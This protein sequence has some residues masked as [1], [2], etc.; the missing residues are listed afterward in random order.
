MVT[1]LLLLALLPDAREVAV[2][3][4]TL[5]A[6]SSHNWPDAEAVA[7]VVV[8]RADAPG[9]RP[10]LSG[11]VTQPGQFASG[12]PRARMRPM[13]Y[14]IALRARLRLLDPPPWLEPDVFWF[15]ASWSRAM[16]LWPSRYDEVGR[17]KRLRRAGTMHVYWR[18]RDGRLERRGA[19]G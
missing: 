7:A 12:C 11:V 1:V 9:F 3:A 4:D 8:N 17:T 5:C 6:E 2:V 18:L 13:H 15:C 19:D 14:M 16:R 10:T